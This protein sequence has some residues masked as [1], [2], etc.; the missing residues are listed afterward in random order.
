MRAAARA[1]R[2]TAVVMV[3]MEGGEGEGGGE[4]GGEGWR[5]G[6]RGTEGGEGGECGGSGAGPRGG[7]GEGGGE[8]GG[9][10]GVAARAPG[11][12]GC[13]RRP[14]SCS[15]SYLLKVRVRARLGVLDEVSG[16][17]KTQSLHFWLGSA[18]GLLGAW[19][20]MGVLFETQTPTPN[21][22]STL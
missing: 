20:G 11:Y 2:A 5:R 18:L 10:E 1:A 9:G 3:G 8:G 16:S 12:Q 19:V 4:G 7:G 15:H 13:Y 14:W 17:D 6:R 21:L 22:S